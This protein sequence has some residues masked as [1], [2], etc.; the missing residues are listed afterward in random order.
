VFF[1]F[2]G[3]DPGVSFSE[4]RVKTF[5]ERRVKTFVSNKPECELRT[6]ELKKMP[7]RYGL[8]H[9]AVGRP[10]H[11]GHLATDHTGFE[12]PSANSPADKHENTVR[13]SVRQSDGLAVVSSDSLGRRAIEFDRSPCCAAT[14]VGD[15]DAI[16]LF[17]RWRLP[18]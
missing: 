14:L 6:A 11:F 8:A 4:R 1:S 15:L 16:R 18:T 17:A 10:V 2:S 9:A 3:N 5:R 7:T 13:L 12:T